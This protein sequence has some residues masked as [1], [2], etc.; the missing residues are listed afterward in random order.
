MYHYNFSGRRVLHT[1]VD[2]PST[3]LLELRQCT[4]LAAKH[5][6]IAK[7]NFTGATFANMHFTIQVKSELQCTL[8]LV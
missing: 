7:F 4:T 2:Y 8:L 6:Y 3:A 5:K 1:N